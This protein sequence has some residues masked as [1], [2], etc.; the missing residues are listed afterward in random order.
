MVGSFRTLSTE[1][2]NFGIRHKD[3]HTS[4]IAAGSDGVGNLLV[5]VHVSSKSQKYASALYLL[6]EFHL[7][8]QNT[9]NI[10]E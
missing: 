2:G 4:G 7:H 3:G 10:E 5:C 6:R 8:M 9:Q 1:Q